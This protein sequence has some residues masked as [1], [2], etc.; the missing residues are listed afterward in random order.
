MISIDK[1]YQTV[2]MF[3]NSDIRGNVKPRDLRLAINDVVNEIYEGYFAD[4]NRA[5][6]R[7][8]RGLIG[9]GLQNIADRIGER[10]SHFLIE[11]LEL[12]YADP[13]FEIPT[14]Y[15]YIESVHFDENEIQMCKSNK[16]FRLIS[17]NVDTA[18]TLNYPIGLLVANIVEDE[19]IMALKV[20]PSTITDKVFLTY[21]RKPLL[22]NWTFNMVNGAEVFNPS[23]AD[24][25]DI[26]MH[27]GEENNIV[28]G[29]LNRFGINLKEED[30]VA[31]TERNN[32]QDFNQDNAV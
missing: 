7:E 17:R 2:L 28:M 10:Q 6:N 13:Y 12:T 4:I 23:A 25:R 29:V 20:G 26:D 15:R 8:N 30:L 27:P 18:P 19:E 9:G 31:F 32:A 5:L 11:D 16:E 14:N 24:F 22:A 3:A 21:L 1:V